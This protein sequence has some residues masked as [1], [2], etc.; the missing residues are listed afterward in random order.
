VD[1][2]YWI[3]VVLAGRDL[4]VMIDLGLVDPLHRV[5]LE[6]EAVL[7][8]AMKRAGNFSRLQM[9]PRRAASGGL[10][11]FETGLLTA[12]LVDPALRQPIGPVAS[13]FVARS[14]PGVPNRVGVVFFH[15]LVGSRVTWELDGQ[16]W[17]IDCP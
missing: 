8:D 16:V 1:G 2:R 9:R 3:D 15:Q 4:S 13:V 17:Q 10:T 14:V 11:W 5:G 7:Y 6:I 12:Q